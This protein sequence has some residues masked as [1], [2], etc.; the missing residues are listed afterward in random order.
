MPDYIFA[1]QK[2][3]KVKNTV[4]TSSSAYIMWNSVMPLSDRVT[5]YIVLVNGKKAAMSAREQA[6]LKNVLCVGYKDIFYK[7]FTKK[8]TLLDNGMEKNDVTFY[9]VENLEPETEYSI[10]VSAVTKWGKP[11]YISDSVKVVTKAESKFVNILD[12]GAKPSLKISS[13]QNSGDK[14]FIK[15]NTEC[16]QKAIDECPSGGT[17]YIPE[18]I[19]MSG[20]LNLK[21]DMTLK[22][23]GVLCGSP[24]A[25]HYEFGYLLYPYYTDR[26]Y[27]GLLNAENAENISITGGGNGTIDGNGWLYADENNKPYPIIK[28]Y[29]EEGDDNKHPLYRYVKGNNKTVYEYGLLAKS[30]ALSYLDSIGKTPETAETEELK[31]AYSCR[32]TMMIL[33]GVKNLFLEGLIVVNPANHMINIQDSKNITVTGLRELSYDINNGDGLGLLC[34]QDAYIFNNFI[35]TGD[36]CIVFSAGVGKEAFTTG[37]SPVS[38]IEICGNYFHHGHGGVVCGSHTAL[39]IENIFVHDNVFNHT[40]IGLRLKS[41]PANGGYVKNI[42]FEHN[43]L[44]YVKR[45]FHMTTEYSD[46]GT[47]SQYHAADTPAVFSDIKCSDCTIYKSSSYPVYIYADE[48]YPHHDISFKNVRI[49][50]ESYQ[51]KSVRNCTNYSF[52]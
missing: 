2:A 25:E 7:S 39:G 36:D 32:S 52:E 15:H 35:D 19:F 5:D 48:A 12:Y 37:Q 20:G 21:S 11:I 27:R 14:D 43:A 10:S 26:R 38:N 17:V 3:I 50:P 1:A 47:V 42:I 18:G 9:C 28:F 22:I 23:D 49:S 34:C 4:T 51:R 29:A 30:C 31:R 41:A 16:I 6:L 44:A 45:A 33:R 24:F 46:S 13:T 40:D 8:E